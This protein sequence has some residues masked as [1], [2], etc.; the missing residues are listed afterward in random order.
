MLAR[1]NGDFD[2]IVVHAVA[3]MG[4]L[5][6]DGDNARRLR[7]HGLA[8][9]NERQN[10]IGAQPLAEHAAVVVDQPANVVRAAGT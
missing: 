6:R 7:G 5:R 3:D 2:A 1:R 10:H 4:R 9:E 8:N